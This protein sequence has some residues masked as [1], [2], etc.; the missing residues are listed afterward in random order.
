[1]LAITGM[2]A[3]AWPPRVV[4]VTTETNRTQFVLFDTQ[5]WTFE[6]CLAAISGILIQ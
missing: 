2:R 3:Y 1:M 5:N 4:P 6:P